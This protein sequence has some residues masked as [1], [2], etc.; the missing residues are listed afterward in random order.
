MF[1]FPCRSLSGFN[2]LHATSRWLP[3]FK[4]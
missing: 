3:T 4:A 1:S 2:R